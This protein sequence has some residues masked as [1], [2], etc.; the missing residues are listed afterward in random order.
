MDKVEIEC[1]REIVRPFMREKRFLHTLGVEKEARRLG[2][3][4]IPEKCDKLSVAGLLHDITKEF[5]K[6]KQLEIARKYGR[7]NELISFPPVLW[8]SITGCDYA[9]EKFGEELVDDEIYNSIL[10]HTT[11]N[12]KMTIFDAIIYLSDYIE[13]NR[14]FYDCVLLRNYFYVNLEKCSTMAEKKELLRK[15]MIFS[16]DLTIKGLI[17][18]GKLVDFDTVKARNYFLKNNDCF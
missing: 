12:E 18:D 16:F 14:T 10:Y 9:R 13:E 8:H 15:T 6:E 4:F 11:G 3:I 1:I 5:S 2:E 17:D 7:E